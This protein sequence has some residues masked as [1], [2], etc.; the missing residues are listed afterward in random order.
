MCVNN[1]DNYESVLKLLELWKLPQPS[2][3]L[4]I[5]GGAK[6]FEFA[7]ARIPTLFKKGVIDIATTTG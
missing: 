7:K 6:R 1:E 4:S 3:I 2:L 5:I